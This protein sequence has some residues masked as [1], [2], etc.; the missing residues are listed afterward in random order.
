M[1][2]LK[3]IRKEGLTEDL[4]TVGLKN[5][6]SGIKPINGSSQKTNAVELK[7]RNIFI[8]E[9]LTIQLNFHKYS[10]VDTNFPLISDSNTNYT[11]TSI[12][13]KIELV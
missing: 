9:L 11:L 2:K 1:D 5:L 6:Y 10:S 12:C 4:Q 7:Y 13:S 8:N 3:Y